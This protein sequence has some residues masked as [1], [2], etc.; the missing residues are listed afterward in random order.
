VHPI[1]FKLGPLAIHS[2]GLM[3]ALSFVIG[4]QVA[5]REGAR[6][7]L[8]VDQLSTLCLWILALA[9]V[10]AR[11]LYV[12]S[13]AESYAGR[14][15]DAFKLWEG[16]LT[17]YGGFVAALAGA[18]FYTRRHRLPM[19]TVF[20]AFSPAIALGS[21]ITRLG[22]FLNGC[23]FGR[24]CDLPWGVTFGPDSSPGRIYP[25]L[26]LHPTQLYMSLV[27][28]L[29]FFLLT[30]WSRRFTRP[31]QLFFVFLFIESGSRLVI[32]FFRHY[33]P[34]G[35]SVVLG[36]IQLSL[37]QV[38]CLVLVVTAAVGLVSGALRRA[39][40]SPAAPAAPAVRSDP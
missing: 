20:D 3:L 16:G 7:G 1:L 12:V 17:M 27:G 4:A 38:V 37:T 26:E 29:N 5:L 15:L 35:E 39:P 13:H 31:G 25:G 14:W 36:G 19:G 30:R 10:G 32:D 6:R 34:G 11:M 28:F 23:C 22:C 24:P 8:P 33:E 21:G 18:W 2:Y 9:V 40:A